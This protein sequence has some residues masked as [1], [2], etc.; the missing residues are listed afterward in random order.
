MRQTGDKTAWCSM[1]YTRIRATGRPGPADSY[2]N[3]SRGWTKTELVRFRSYGITAEAWRA[4]F[5]AQ[6]EQ[7]AGCGSPEP[8]TRRGWHTDHDHATGAVLGILCY[9]C[10]IKIHGDTT[11]ADLVGLLS[12]FRRTRGCH[13]TCDRNVRG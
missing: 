11:E 8:K 9:S 12:Y 6:G 2:T 3:H 1:H 10:N 5:I 13:E 4:M 7:C